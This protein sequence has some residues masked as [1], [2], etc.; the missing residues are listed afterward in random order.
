MLLRWVPA[1]CCP[2]GLLKYWFLPEN[3]LDSRVPNPLVS[4]EIIVCNSFYEVG[5]FLFWEVKEY[6][7]SVLRADFHHA[8]K[9]FEASADE[10]L[11]P[12]ALDQ[13][14]RPLRIPLSASNGIGNNRLC[15][16]VCHAKHGPIR[17]LDFCQIIFW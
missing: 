15:A 14:D 16:F 3:L 17:T 6:F 5:D 9:G 7:S 12:I 2:N 10:E 11:A 13:E 4:W 8:K 1:S